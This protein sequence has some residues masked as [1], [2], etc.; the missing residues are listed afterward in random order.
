MSNTQTSTV[1]GQGKDAHSAFSDACNKI[2]ES[3]AQNG[4]AAIDL[5]CIGYKEL[6]AFKPAQ[7]TTKASTAFKGQKKWQQTYAAY[8]MN[9][10]TGLW[11][12][13]KLPDDID[14]TMKAN[15]QQIARDLCLTYQCQT[16]VRVERTLINDPNN[17]I[18]ETYSPVSIRMG[19]WNF[20]I[21]YTVVPNAEV[22]YGLA[23]PD[24]RVLAEVNAAS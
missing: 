21:Q 10:A 5:Y 11:M 6:H 4:Q 7:R 23:A 24:T 15:I 13:A 8:I 20:E 1:T 3:A 19:T 18:E 12:K 9:E 14:I 17:Q 22:A 2:L 16:C